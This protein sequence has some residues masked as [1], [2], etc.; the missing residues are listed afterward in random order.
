MQNRR[1]NEVYIFGRKF[2]NKS[3][4]IKPLCITE[5]NLLLSENESILIFSIY[6]DCQEFLFCY[7]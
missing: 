4:K 6:K 5:F 1:K 3:F 7:S 2:Q